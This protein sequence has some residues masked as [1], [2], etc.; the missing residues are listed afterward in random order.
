METRTKDVLDHLAIHETGHLIV[1]TALARTCYQVTLAPNREKGHAGS[2]IIGEHFD[3]T[4]GCRRAVA[5]FAGGIE[6]ENLIFG[7]PVIR[8]SGSEDALRAKDAA[9]KIV[10]MIGTVADLKAEIQRGR[11]LARKILEMNE[12]QLRE[13]SNKMLAFHVA[14]N[15]VRTLDMILEEAMDK[16][17][18][19]YRT[20]KKK[21][22]SISK[23]R[24]IADKKRT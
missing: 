20:A 6:A 11:Y 16:S 15:Q 4:D 5:V 21:Q 13:I 19:E 3:S 9:R 1:G 12:D 14:F 22:R 7:S 23:R 8:W 10:G 18:Q 24:K 2:C 17:F